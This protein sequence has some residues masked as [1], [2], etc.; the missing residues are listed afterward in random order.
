MSVQQI[1]RTIYYDLATGNV[2]CDTGE[3]RGDVFD[4][5]EDQDFAAFPQLQGLNKSTVCVLNLGYGDYATDYQ[6][7]YIS[8]VDPN[9]QAVTFTPYPTPA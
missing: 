1:G 8:H 6:T 5:T 7:G 9:T 3:R 4:T 2:L